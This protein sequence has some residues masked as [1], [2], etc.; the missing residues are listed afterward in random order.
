MPK[1]CG[2]FSTVE[3]V[4]PIPF[5]LETAFN[6]CWRLLGHFLAL[7]NRIP[8]L[9]PKFNPPVFVFPR[10]RPWSSPPTLPRP[11]FV[12]NPI[13]PGAQ[14]LRSFAVQSVLGPS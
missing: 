6:F 3:T 1:A 10:E 7:G 13:N 11:V 2:I 8:A 12:L 5:N 9:F 14:F 4:S